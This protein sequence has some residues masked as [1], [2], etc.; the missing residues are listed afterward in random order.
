MGSIR[1]LASSSFGKSTQRAADALRE[2][3]ND[4]VDAGSSAAH[5]RFGD[6]ME[7]LQ[8]MFGRAQKVSGRELTSLRKQ[9]SKKLDAASVTLDAIGGDASVAAQRTLK[10]TNELIRARPM[11]AIGV[12]AVTGLVL[13]FLLARRQGD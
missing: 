5:D 10:S 2:R 1:N 12:V 11:Q 3:A 13:G 4:A 9:M 7:D 6:L 8:A